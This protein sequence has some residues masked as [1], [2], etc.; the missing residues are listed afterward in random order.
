[1]E[2]R[3]TRNRLLRLVLPAWMACMG[4][5][6]LAAP[7]LPETAR[8]AVDRLLQ[9]QTAGL[10]GKATVT[11]NSTGSAPLPACDDFEAFM[12]TGTTLWGRVS[13]GLRCRS[14]KPWSRFISAHVAVEGSYFVAA[15]AI[16]AGEALGAADVVERT[17]DLSALPRS[18][19]TDV[20]ALRGVTSTHR[21]AAGAPLRKELMRGVVVIQQGQTV[22]LVAQGQGYAVS[23]E[24]KAMTRAEVGATVQA[25]TRDG[26]LLSGVAGEDGQVRLAQ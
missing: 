12:P 13:I 20:S 3:K 14:D 23:T 7:Q 22:Q 5:A 21:I 15:R 16:E 11:F 2:Q 26:R 19:V 1:M 25:R 10:P 24:G 8:A 9:A 18:V 4:T 6:S 17:G